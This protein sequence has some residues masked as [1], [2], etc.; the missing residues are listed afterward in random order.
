MELLK[1]LNLVLFF[2]LPL[3]LV[4]KDSL[5]SPFILLFIISSIPY[6][7]QPKFNRIHF[8]F[9]FLIASYT[10]YLIGL[11]YTKNL[12]YGIKDIETKMSFFIFPVL[13]L[14]TQKN[15]PKRSANFAKRGLI[16]GVG[17]SITISL[18]R[19]LICNYND[20]LN[21]FRADVFGFN[22]HATY[23][24]ALCILALVF[25]LDIQTKSKRIILF[26]F[27]F[28]SAV[29]VECY[30]V[31]S[32]SSYLVIF[33][34]VMSYFIYWIFETKYFKVLFIIPVI[35]TLSILSLKFLPQVEK[36]IR[37]TTLK[38]KDF[39]LDN[40]KFLIQNRNLNE[41]NTVRL[42][43]YSI[44]SEIVMDNPFGVGTGDVKD[45]LMSEYYKNGY[46]GYAEAKYNSHNTFLQTGISIGWLG[47]VCLLGVLLL[48]FFIKTFLSHKVVILF[49]LI[50]LISSTFESFL[51]RQVGVILLSFF[52]FV[53]L[54]DVK[55]ELLKSQ[56]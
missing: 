40:E 32:L 29:L 6:F 42:V 56:K 37:V 38:L 55:P 7:S 49:F 19:A 30:F 22:M 28:T 24:S 14:L 34:L 26:K 12:N 21:C 52:M 23:L 17:I 27:V 44:S 9:Y 11:V 48:P 18:I 2:L 51:E 39:L 54:L 53:L 20:G 5:I 50:V 25:V 1:K 31:R 36:D 45:L 13:F 10:L 43:T 4:V 3:V 47:I 35:L 46:S 33:L 16:I 8:P 15:I 41:S